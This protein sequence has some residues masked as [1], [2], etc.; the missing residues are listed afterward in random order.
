MKKLLFLL[1]LPFTLS[2]QYVDTYS[3][4]QT[5]KASG[6]LVSGMSYMITDLGKMEIMARTINSFYPIPIKRT[7]FAMDY[8]YE[9]FN[10]DTKVITGYDNIQCVARCNSG[11]WAL[12]NDVGHTPYKAAYASNNL[13]VHFYK[14]YDKVISSSTNIDDGYAASSLM[15]SCGASV[16]FNY[17]AVLLY[18]TVF[19]NGIP[20]KVQM[21]L[22]EASIAGANIF[23][24]VTMAKFI[25]L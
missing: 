19:N 16:S 24:Y 1:L 15:I 7:P 18:K 22:M 4:I 14:T 17:I 21:T 3:N 13:M 10:F 8:D 20:T 9:T 11:V 23:L 25:P 2:A 12:I 6:L 5:L